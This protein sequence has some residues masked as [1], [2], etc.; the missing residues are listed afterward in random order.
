MV[1]PGVDDGGLIVSG[2]GPGGRGRG[3]PHGGVTGGVGLA[4]QTSPTTAWHCQLSVR[5]F[6]ALK[7]RT[8]DLRFELV[9]PNQIL[10]INLDFI[11]G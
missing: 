8:I 1:D 4:T 9:T 6:L 2:G 3:R 5:H 10:I 11:R 7:G